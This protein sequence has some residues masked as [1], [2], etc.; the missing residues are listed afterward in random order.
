[1]ALEQVFK[2]PLVL[3]K[4]RDGPLG[5]LT[6]RFCDALLQGGFAPSTIRRHLSNIAHLN[7]YIGTR[8][9]ADGQILSAQTVRDF[10]ETTGHGPGIGDRWIGILPV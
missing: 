8:D 6:D 1:M 5:G 9:Q 10:S 2:C 7:A 4:L 3:S